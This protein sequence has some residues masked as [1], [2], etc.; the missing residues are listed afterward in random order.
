[1]EKHSPYAIGMRFVRLQVYILLE[2]HLLLWKTGCVAAVSLFSTI[3][4]QLFTKNKCKDTFSNHSMGRRMEHH[5]V[6]V[7]DNYSQIID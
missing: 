6:I 5:R 7:I 3:Q 1:M 2:D 4:Q